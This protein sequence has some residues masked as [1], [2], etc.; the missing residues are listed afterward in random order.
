MSHT[1]THTLRILLQSCVVAITFISPGWAQVQQGLPTQIKPDY[2]FSSP[3]PRDSKS[4]SGKPLE[5]DSLGRP[6]RSINEPKSYDK[7]TN[8]KNDP[9]D[10]KKSNDRTKKDFGPKDDFSSGVRCFNCGTII[11]VTESR[12]KAKPVWM[13]TTDPNEATSSEQAARNAEKN[14]ERNPERLESKSSD[15]FQK[16]SSSPVKLNGTL[17]KPNSEFTLQRKLGF[18]TVVKM[19]DG[20]MKT[21]VTALQPAYNIGAKVRVIGNSLSPR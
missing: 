5:T 4:S 9:K 20:T 18:E 10:F 6:I 15:Q 3:D 7:G 17:A 8:N 19:E 12:K 14:A 21:V 16:S 11:S 13:S 1:T 2:R